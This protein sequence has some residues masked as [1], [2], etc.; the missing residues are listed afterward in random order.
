[1]RILYKVSTSLI[2]ALGI[3]HI[4]L[5]PVLFR[6]FTS[7]ALWFVSGGVM[8]AF[9]SF[10]NFILMSEAGKERVVKIFCNTANLISLVFA[11]AMLILES[12]R[13]HPGPSAWLVLAVLVFETIAAFRYSLRPKL[14]R[15]P[16][17]NI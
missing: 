10:F 4:C 8:I 16:G 7:A 1:M 13:G 6:G 17:G 12:R 2:L 14:S 15:L 9:V 3:L 5:S 11:G